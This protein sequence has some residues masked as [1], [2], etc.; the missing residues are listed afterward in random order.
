MV[1]REPLVGRTE[2]LAILQDRLAEAADGAGR[3]ILVSGP[4]GMGKTRL[5]EELL[6]ATHSGLVG[7]GAALPGAGI[8]PLWPWTRAVRRLPGPRTAVGSALSTSVGSGAASDAAA[9]EF[10]RHTVVLDALEDAAALEPPLVIVLDDLH[11]ADEA[12]LRLLDRLAA[13][14][15]RLPI[16]I[17][18]THRPTGR[19][20]LTRILPALRARAGTEILRLNPLTPSDARTLL[21]RAV[22]H[23]DTALVDRIAAG[24]GGNPLYLHT[25]A[26]AAPDV[27]RRR[28]EPVHTVWR[29]PE[30]RDVV[31][32]TVRDLGA[33]VTGLLEALSVLGVGTGLR[34]LNGVVG[35]DADLEGWLGP[36]I[37]SALVERAG[38]EVRF[39]HAVLRDAVYASLSPHR[40]AAL[41]VRAAEILEV[42]ARTEPG[43]AGGV[44]EHWLRAGD[45][46]AGARW[47]VRAATIASR[48]G[49][50]RRAADLLTLA[51]DAPELALDAAADDRDRRD[52][53]RGGATD[54]SGEGSGRIALLLALARARY[55]S[56]DL[57]ASLVACEQATDEGLVR[58]DRR[59]PARAAVVIQGVSD[60]ALIQRLRRLSEQALEA[61]GPSGEPEL[62][63]RVEA[64]LGHVARE[65]EDWQ[66]AL[67]WSQLALEHAVLSESAE[68][69]LDAIG[70]R[71]PLTLA[72]GQATERLE[73]GLRAIE[74]GRR[75]GRVLAEL[76]GHVWRIDADA[77]LV[78][79][80]SAEAELAE[81]AALADRTGLPLVRWHLLRQQAAW[82]AL[83]GEFDPA[84]Q[85]SVDAADI[86]A[87]LG[88]VS[89]SGIH[90]AFVVFVAMLRGQPDIIPDRALAELRSYARIPVVQASHALALLLIG[91]AAEA[92]AV[93]RA[94]PLDSLDPANPLSLRMLPDALELAVEFS[95]VPGCRRIAAPLRV[96]HQRARV[97]GSGTTFFL[98]SV[99]RALGRVELTIGDY[100]PAILHLEEGLGVDTLLG[101]RPYAAQGR[102]A[103][104]TALRRRA[105]AADLD[106]AR[107]LAAQA[108]TEAQSLRLIRMA[109][110]AKDVL[111]ALGRSPRTLDRLTARE[112]EIAA[113]VARAQNNRDIASRLVL[114][115]RTV[116]GHIRSI[117]AKT[118]QPS[119][120]ALIA[121]LVREAEQA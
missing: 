96:I 69:E 105:A 52:R 109:A 7:W 17:I 81:L 23:A 38:G 118:G 104:A 75:L 29:L 56:G 1:R 115:E 116:E 114:S 94:L 103:L 87:E 65:S 79:L 98:G 106:R 13:E 2:E 83:R 34:T 84:L 54:Q 12:T 49:A 70:A 50:H 19:E 21:C 57:T 68:A 31:I 20:G 25:I 82:A 55:L 35:A 86:A 67:R 8:P 121:Q 66:Q 36:A 100:E 63:A 80:T 108:G 88:D 47:A 45:R 74:L 95:D 42:A 60:P 27:L 77:E 46:A 16:M 24:A 22:P 3:L 51:L 99:A 28:A 9:A 101:A 44:A 117:L 110:E 15:R 90:L 78:D 18:G 71:G 111:A 5:S 43:L 76:W 92:E 85:H 30:L 4:A 58:G 41:H 26:R 107:R 112:R 73:T 10:A 102:L 59:C 53:T 61:L 6:A 97:I 113:L 120:A 91:R 64:Q 37:A 72:P 11:W 48:A 14:I 33:G 39:T 32:A 40:R 93:Y 62:R 119:R 89:G